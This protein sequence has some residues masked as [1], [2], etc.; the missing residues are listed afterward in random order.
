MEIGDTSLPPAPGSGARGAPAAPGS[1][2]YYACMALRDRMA[3]AAGLNDPAAYRS[4]MG[5][6][7]WTAAPAPARLPRRHAPEGLEAEGEITPGEEME[8]YFQASYGAHFARSRSTS[9]PASRVCAVCRGLRRGRILT[10]RP[11]APRRS[12]GS[13]WG[14]GSAL[15]RR[16][17]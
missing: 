8:D 9:T 11:P 7:R 13:F 14:L 2:V 15:T 6:S 1:G 12:A 3:R 16:P 17:S 10:P 4:T 5:R